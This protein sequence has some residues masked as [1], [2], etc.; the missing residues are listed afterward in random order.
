Q[1][2]GQLDLGDCLGSPLF[3]RCVISSEQVE[4]APALRYADLTDD[5]RGVIVV[6]VVLFESDTDIDAVSSSEVVTDGVDAG[7][8]TEVV[9]F[10]G[11]SAIPE[12]G[13]HTDE[14]TAELDVGV[15]EGYVVLVGGTVSNAV[16]VRVATETAG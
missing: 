3:E 14:Q 12:G 7:V 1:R 13:L 9:V 11:E 8:V 15:T 10:T 5:V 4:G 2:I 16:D 6:V